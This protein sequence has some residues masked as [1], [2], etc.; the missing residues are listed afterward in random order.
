MMFPPEGLEEMTGKVATAPPDYFND[1]NAIH[2]A[3]AVLTLEQCDRFNR[4][5]LE[6]KPHPREAAHPARR[7]T[8]GSTC[9]DMFEALGQT[10]KLWEAGD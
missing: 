7:W 6:V 5:L 10:L 1:L 2:S 4:V 8:W 9:A 3:L